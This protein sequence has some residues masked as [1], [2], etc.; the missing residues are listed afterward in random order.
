MFFKVIPIICFLWFSCFQVKSQ[1][2]FNIENSILFAD[3]LKRTKQYE[4][5]ARE[6][7]RIIFL[8]PNNDSIRLSLIQVYFNAG[9]YST[10]LK[11]AGKIY[12]STSNL[13]KPFAM[14]YSR[15][16]LLNDSIIRLN[17]F[18]KNNQYLVPEEV[19]K[20][21][22]YSHMMSEN[23]E[24]AEKISLKKQDSYSEHAIIIKQ[25]L[26]HK[27]KSPFIASGLSILVPGAGKIYTRDWKDGI[28]SFLVVGSMAFQSYRGFVK[29]GKEGSSGWIYGSIGAVFYAGNI[30][31]THKAAKKY[32]L[33]LKEIVRDKTKNLL[34]THY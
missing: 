23:W 2:L 26:N 13:P 28:F 19:D 31:G 30:Y 34:I 21:L 9:D 15:L 32:N 6:Y 8:D 17:D 12:P 18:I 7:E 4:F 22:L 5:A 14:E 10:A 27:F 20:I 25:A 24:E 33:K 29:N 11:K 16:L 3:F 1:D